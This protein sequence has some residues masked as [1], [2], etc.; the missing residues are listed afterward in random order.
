MNPPDYIDGARVIK[1]AWS[2]EKPFGFV[3][4]ENDPQKEEIYGLAICKYED[5]DG[6]YRFSCGKDWETVQDGYYN[7][8]AE[9]LERLPEQYKN[10]TAHW[11]SKP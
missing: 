6:I 8:V 4:D 3:G 1:W 11:N 10:V 2:G 9:A 5:G 7:T